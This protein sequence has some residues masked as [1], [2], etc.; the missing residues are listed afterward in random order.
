MEKICISSHNY[1]LGFQ[2]FS[3]NEDFN[4]E[5]L[6]K[7][8]LERCSNT[9]IENVGETFLRI[10]YEVKEYPVFVKI[11]KAYQN[12]NYWFAVFELYRPMY[13]QFKGHVDNTFIYMQGNTKIVSIAEHGSGVESYLKGQEIYS[14]ED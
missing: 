8:L 5:K 9:L 3:Y 1:L 7:F 12:N 4:A 13:K 14:C 2:Q 11:K 6:Q 10:L